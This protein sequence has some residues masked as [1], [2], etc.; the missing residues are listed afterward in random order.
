[1]RRLIWSLEY[2]VQALFPLEDAD[3]EGAKLASTQ[4]S[5]GQTAVS[6]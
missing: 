3:M 4:K 2:G 1:M 6:A 5:G